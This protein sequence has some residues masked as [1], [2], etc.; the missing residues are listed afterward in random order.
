V[1][2]VAQKQGW[3]ACPSGSLP[4]EQIERMVVDRIKHI[5]GDAALIAATFRQLQ[6]GIRSR[7]AQ[8]DKDH[9]AS[10]REIQKIE[11]DIR[12]AAMT[13]GT[14]ANAAAR[15]AD[16]HERLATASERARVLCAE[17]EQIENESITQSDVAASLREFAATWDVLYPRE[18]AA[19]LANLVK[20]VDYDG[21]KKTVSITFHPAGLR[22]LGQAP[23]EHE[24]VA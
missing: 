14:D 23:V 12:K 1:C 4:A 8:I 22:T 20:R 2:Y 15:L 10:T 7:S 13:A 16:L 6:I 21:A 3:H 11:G 24:E 19:V 18:Q 9:T 5:G 17:A